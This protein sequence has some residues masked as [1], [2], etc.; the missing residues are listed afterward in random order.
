MS[1][2]V[3]SL[4][5]GYELSGVDVALARR[6]KYFKKS[7]EMIKYIFTELPSLIYI[8]R[9]KKLGIQLNEM[10]S[11]HLKLSNV[12]D[13]SG[14][15]L[16]EQKIMELKETMGIDK[17]VSKEKE[18]TLYKNGNRVAVLILKEDTRFFSTIYFY[19]RERLIGEE[20]YT[21]RLLYIKHY[22][23]S[24]YN[25]YLYAKLKR[26][27]FLDEKGR[28]T[29]ECLHEEN[30]E[31]Y[32]YP[33]GKCLSKYELIE[34][35]IVDLK[36]KEE[37]LVV[38]DRPSYMNFV[39]PLLQ[40][41]NN[42]KLITFL[43][44][45]HY[46]KRGESPDA[47]FMNYEYYGWF[48]YSKYIDVVIVS[49]EEQKIDLIEK[50]RMYGCYVP[51]IEVIPVSG[52]D[53]VK[54]PQEKRQP[55]SLITVSRIDKR[56]NIPWIIK[57][58]IEAKKILPEIVLDIYG[59][60]DAGYINSL[61]DYLNEKEA[62][63]FIRFRGKADVN[64]LY[65]SYEV[66]ITASLWETLGLSCMEAVGSGNAMIG[67]DVRYGNRLFIKNN[68]NGKLVDFNIDDI[69]KEDIE[70][71]TIEKMKE[72]ILDVF[73]DKERLISFQNNSYIIAKEFMDEQIEQKWLKL[74]NEFIA[75]DVLL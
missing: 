16:V 41:K 34:N 50:C 18:I 62:T 31:K 35:F 55:Y 59:D 49:T 32:I 9:Y 53:E 63:S 14:D 2:Y 36:L 65:K 13:I 6:N 47:L 40:H 68:I 51:K 74:L 28:V 42:A 26:T 52:L 30:D 45:G 22:I 25:G 43:H 46:Y 29:C 19:E 37:D 8:D 3:F 17:V 44:S 27:T 12:D 58:V 70:S 75:E 64:E 5:V 21:D 4:L 23:T 73:E 66:Y 20:F 61:K 67:L 57:S 72:A 38:I 60:G 33:N 10:M 54:Y 15:Y 7:N 1:I 56:K 69:A 24:S 71:I 39:Q 48:R 11:V